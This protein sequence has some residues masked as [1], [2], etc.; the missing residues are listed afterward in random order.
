MSLNENEYKIFYLSM[1]TAFSLCLWVSLRAAATRLAKRRISAC[2]AGHWRSRKLLMGLF[3]L[4]MLIVLWTCT[5]Q[6]RRR[7]MLK[8]RSAKQASPKRLFSAQ[9]A[10]SSLCWGLA[11]MANCPPTRKSCSCRR[12][13]ALN[14]LM[15]AVKA[16]WNRAARSPVSSP[17]NLKTCGNNNFCR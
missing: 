13:T 2:L 7:N 9:W 5:E 8:S 16:V 10:M 6:F 14:S 12:V 11:G 17:T 3:R 4:N 15:S 1:M